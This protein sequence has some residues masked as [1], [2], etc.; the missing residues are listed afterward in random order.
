MYGAGETDNY[1]L[2][3]PF[4][5]PPWEEPDDEPEEEDRIEPWEAR[6]DE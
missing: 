6:E 5:T 1:P 2:I 3:S 4:C